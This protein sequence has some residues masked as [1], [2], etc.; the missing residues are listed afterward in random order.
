MRVFLLN[1]ICLM[2]YQMRSKLF[3]FNVLENVKYTLKPRQYNK[4]SKMLNVNVA[5]LQRT[6]KLKTLKRKQN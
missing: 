1:H 4:C 3:N 5:K 6:K 2:N